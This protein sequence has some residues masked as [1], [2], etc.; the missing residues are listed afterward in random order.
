[1]SRLFGVYVAP[2][3]LLL[4]V[5]EAALITSAF[6]LATYF[7]LSV[8]PTVFLLYDDGLSRILLVVLSILLFLHLSDLYN[9]I[10]VS[11]HLA[12]AQQLCMAMGGTFLLHALLSY[13]RPGLRVPIRIMGG[14]SAISLA[15]IYGW[16]VVY[17]RHVLGVVGGQRLLVVGGTPMVA[18]MSEHLERHPELGMRIVGYVGDYHPGTPPVSN[19]KSLGSLSSL[20]EVAEAIK[21]DRILLALSER[22]QQTP[23]DDLLE[24]RYS[25]HR[26]E[27]ASMLYEAVCGRVCAKEIR[28]SQFIFCARLGPR[29]RSLFFQA[30]VNYSIALTGILLTWPIMLLTA[31]AVR[32][33]SPG[34]ILYRQE[35]V[36]LDGAVFTLFKFRSMAADA[37]ARTGAVW[38][39][40]NDPRITPVGRILRKH[41]LDELPQLFNVLLGEMSIVGPRPERPKFVDDFSRQVPYYNERH[42]VR[43]GIT[44][45]A[46]IN[47][48]Y[49][50]TFED[51]IAKLE[52][53]L[54]YI[55]HMSLTLDFYIIFQTVKAMFLTSGA[56]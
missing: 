28:P 43:P 38:A 49:A 23:L 30:L 36:G 45:W 12:L 7:T 46:Q 25:G 6:A 14:G 54:Y 26:I 18:E 17:S 2:S 10:Q 40:K 1:M 41:R 20:R 50:D 15:L 47:Y 44:G 39:T 32:L 3:V 35:R 33:S 42:S 5:S 55:K 34:P 48:K 37:E 52:Y 21:P 8:D 19:G 22:R 53:D 9:Q 27:E 24:L 51:T 56:Q 31:L 29:S 11:S 13:V 4:L 16:R